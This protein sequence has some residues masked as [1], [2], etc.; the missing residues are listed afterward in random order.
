[1][2]I[3]IVVQIL[4]LDFSTHIGVLIYSHYQKLSQFK[5][6]L[7]LNLNDKFRLNFYYFA[8]IYIS[9][10]ALAFFQTVESKKILFWLSDFQIGMNF[11]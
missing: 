3:L 7:P 1:M 11:L 10:W 9:S 5:E 8:D 2:H 4:P 6:S